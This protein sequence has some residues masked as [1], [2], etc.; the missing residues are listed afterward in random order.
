MTTAPRQRGG[1]SHP[2]PIAA[3]KADSH[4]IETRRA[5]DART[6]M[7]LRECL[8]CGN[9]FV[10]HETIKHRRIRTGVSLKAVGE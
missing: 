6:V 3:C 5:S 4:V 10:T 7:R 2:C 8:A 1:V 9:R